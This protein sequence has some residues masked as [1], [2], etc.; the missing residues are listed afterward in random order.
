MRPSV[1]TRMRGHPKSDLHDVAGAVTSA[2][3]QTPHI[4]RLE[5]LVLLTGT[6]GKAK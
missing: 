2:E 6:L 3:S 5:D 1:T 4:Q